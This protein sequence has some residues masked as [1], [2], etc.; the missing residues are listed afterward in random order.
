VSADGQGRTRPLTKQESHGSLEPPR[1]A[2]R[3]RLG[4][5]FEEA[6]RQQLIKFELSF[7]ANPRPSKWCGPIPGARA[8]TPSS[9]TR[10]FVDASRAFKESAG[11]PGNG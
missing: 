5:A 2:R 11:L 7:R 10:G 4:A 1:Q 6:I 8:I 3:G 9:T